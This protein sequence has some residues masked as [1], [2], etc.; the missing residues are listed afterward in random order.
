[1]PCRL[2]CSCSSVPG[3]ALL[4]RRTREDRNFFD[5]L[6]KILDPDPESRLGSENNPSRLEDHPFFRGV[7]WAALAAKKQR[8]PWRPSGKI[9]HLPNVAVPENHPAFQ[10]EDKEEQ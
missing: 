5:L 3:A 4:P 6:S 10:L 2:R 9:E 1:M 7:D 8:A